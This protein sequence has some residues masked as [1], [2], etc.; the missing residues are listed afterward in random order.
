MVSICQTN[1]RGKGMD[2]QC[3]PSLACSLENDPF[4]S[5]FT[6]ITTLK[7]PVRRKEDAI[8]LAHCLNHTHFLTI[9]IMTNFLNIRENF[10]MEESKDNKSSTWAS[11]LRADALPFQPN[12]VAYSPC[13]LPS[14]PVEEASPPQNNPVHPLCLDPISSH[15]LK[16]FLP[17][18]S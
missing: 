7:A 3:S 16:D 18:K 9:C 15:F 14:A 8:S 5:K 11:W 6:S 2:R 1:F 17:Q 13:W 12:Q 4:F 10:A